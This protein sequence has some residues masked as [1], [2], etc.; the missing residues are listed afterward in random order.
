MNPA[1]KILKF[2]FNAEEFARRAPQSNKPDKKN[3]DA[4]RGIAE[5]HGNADYKLPNQEDRRQIYDLFVQASQSGGSYQEFNT[6]KR[7]RQLSWA[8]TFSENKQ[9]RIV[10]TPQLLKDALQLIENRF[11]TSSLLGVFYALIQAWDTTLNAKLL[12]EFVKKHLIEYNGTR[13]SVLKLKRNMNRYCEEDSTTQLAVEL[14]RSDRKLADVWSFLELPD[15]TH[16]YRYFGAVAEAFVSC[17]RNIDK[18]ILADVINFLEKHNND[19]TSRSVLSTLIEQLGFEASDTLRAPVQ[20]YA[21]KQWG[22]PQIAGADVSWRG[23]SSE[24]RKIFTKWFTEADLEFFFGIVAKA[25]NDSKFKYRKAFWLAYLEHITF[26]RPVLQ[27][28]VEKLFIDNLEALRFYEERHPATLTGGGANIHAFIIQMKDYTFVEF[29]TGG[30]CYVY[31]NPP[32]GLY[33]VSYS[34]KELKRTD[35]KGYSNTLL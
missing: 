34:V 33:E 25:C 28:N 7:I 18:D 10:D 27:K 12:R 32:F 1:E 13:K 20:S 35:L 16:G 31:V 15:Y 26:C 24:A 29:S 14:L 22:H 11:R 2:D 5:K 19:Q 6:S 8:L 23:V 4:L 21:L 30:A 17:N 9:P 3:L